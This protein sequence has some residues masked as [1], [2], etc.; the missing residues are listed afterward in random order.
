MAERLVLCGPV[1]R[2]DGAAGD[3]LRLDL[4]G[5]DDNVTL[6][7]QDISR[8]MVAEVSNLHT[9]LL[10]VAAYVYSADA[11]TKRGGEWRSMSRCMQRIVA[12][13]ILSES[14]SAAYWP[15]WYCF[16]SFSQNCPRTGA[17]IPCRRIRW[18]RTSIVSPSMTVA[19]P[20]ISAAEAG[21]AANN[22]TAINRFIGSVLI[23]DAPRTE[24]SGRSVLTSNI[25]HWR[26]IGLRA[27]PGMKIT[28]SL[29]AKSLQ[30]PHQ[31]QSYSR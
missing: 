5:A 27:P 9:D 18:P 15:H 16:R 25:C 19:V 2:P 10:E 21:V 23:L 13:L 3:C 8:R 14:A 24:P 29:A 22:A 4:S 31:S 7:I 17:S 12:C 11:A 30:T 28:G 26:V 6:R 1:D 20:T